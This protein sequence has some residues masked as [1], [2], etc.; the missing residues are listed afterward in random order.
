[1]AAILYSISIQR[2]RPSQIYMYN[3]YAN[4]EQTYTHC[5]EQE[6]FRRQLYVNTCKLIKKY[7][8]RQVFIYVYVYV[9]STVL[10][11]RTAYVCYV[12]SRYIQ[13]YGR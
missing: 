12:T 10:H 6:W 13:L 5:R 2:A 1:M 8:K 3:I 11:M 7:T 9:H 4:I